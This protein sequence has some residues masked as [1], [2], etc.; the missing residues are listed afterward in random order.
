MMIVLGITAV[1]IVLLITILIVLKKR[2]KCSSCSPKEVLISEAKAP[3]KPQPELK[4]AEKPIVNAEPAV[5]SSQIT[6]APPAKPQAKEAA[7]PSPVKS[8]SCSLPQDTILRRHYFTHL[9]IMLETLVPPRPT[10]SVLCRHYDTM[11]VAKI[12]QCLNDNK[13]ME[14]LISDYE[15]ISA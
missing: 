9:C 15:N 10:D 2:K 3:V 5:V 11:I 7:D 13:A 1:L 4:T 6:D 12:A 8:N 14:Q